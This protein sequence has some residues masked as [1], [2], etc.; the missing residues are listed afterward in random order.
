MA[1]YKQ[2]TANIRAHSTMQ[3]QGGPRSPDTWDL[4]QQLQDRYDKSKAATIQASGRQN[5]VVANYADDYLQ[6][7]WNKE[8]AKSRGIY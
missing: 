2:E 5:A 3:A 1:R 8:V 6:Q 4:P 7:T